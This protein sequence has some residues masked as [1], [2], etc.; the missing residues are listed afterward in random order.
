MQIDFNF[1]N[2]T[3]DGILR[4]AF[5]PYYAI[6]GNFTWGI[7]FGFI[8]VAIY[9]NERAIGTTSIYLILVGI[10]VSIIFPMALV[11]VLG[12]LLAFMLGIIFYRAFVQS[13]DA[14]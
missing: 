8:G 7:I 14:Y 10:F 9:A 5:D 3:T 4:V 1:S 2:F 11:T 13:R 6:T 12:M